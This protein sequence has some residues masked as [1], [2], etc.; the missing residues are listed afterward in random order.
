MKINIES[1]SD[2]N[3][4]GVAQVNRT[5]ER[6]DPAFAQRVTIKRARQR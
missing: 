6:T 1:A 4:S 2:A 5:L 3:E